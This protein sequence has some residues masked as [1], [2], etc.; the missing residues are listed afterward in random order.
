MSNYDLALING[1]DIPIVEL[2]TVLHQPNMK[3]FSYLNESDLFKMIQY[4]CVDKS[5][6][7]E[8]KSVLKDITNFQVLMKVVK[9]SKHTDLLINFLSLFFPKARILL[10]PNSIIL[11]YQ[12]ENRNIIID[13]D[14]FIYLQNC[15]REVLCVSSIFQGDNIVYNPVNEKAKAIADK[16]MRGRQK[17]AEIKG[18]NQGSVLARYESIL[19]IGLQMS[20]Y[21]IQKYT[22]YQIFDAIERLNLKLDWDINLK[23]RLAG[24]DPKEDVEN[25]EKD[26]HTRGGK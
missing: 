13:S 21:E 6:L 24:G 26:I 22:M 16:L 19:S 11:S 23:V 7:V 3:E 1:I 9:E 25:W 14:N 2:A 8:D 18:K 12:E 5:S 10:T 4:I 17:V 20:I 15:L